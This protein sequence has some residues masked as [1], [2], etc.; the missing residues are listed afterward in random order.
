MNFLDFH[1]QK[2]LFEKNKIVYFINP[3]NKNK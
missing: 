1:P 2:E 3:F